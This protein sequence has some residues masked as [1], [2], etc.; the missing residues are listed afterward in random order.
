ME[1]LMQMELEFAPTGA[2]VQAAPAK[3][4]EPA[5]YLYKYRELKAKHPDAVLLFRGG[6]YYVT[7]YEDA[8]LIAQVLGV[9]VERRGEG[10]TPQAC[11]PFHALDC[12][13]PKLIRAG[14]RVAICEEIEP[15]PQRKRKSFK[16]PR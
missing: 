7:Y 9:T 10:R 6:D 15:M 1:K 13:L 12:F 3:C 14:Y 16:A 11:F 2:D 4:E 8:Q 5:P